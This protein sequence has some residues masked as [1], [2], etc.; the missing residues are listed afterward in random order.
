MRFEGP[1]PG[2]LAKKLKQTQLSGPT[3]S[4][5]NAKP[6]P[7]VLV[8]PGGGGDEPRLA[9]FR[10]ACEA[11]A[12]MAPIT[13][14]DWR[15]MAGS[16]F[17]FRALLNSILAQIETLAPEGPIHL[18][19]YCLGG[20]LAYAAAVTLSAKGR[21]IAFLGLLDADGNFEAASTRSLADRIR[22]FWVGLKR[23]Y[24]PDQLAYSLAKRLTR[25]LG[26][27]LLRQAARAPDVRMLDEFSLHLRIHV[28]SFLIFALR[29]EWCSSALLSAPPLQTP[30]FLFRATEQKFDNLPDLGW[31]KHIGTIES[32][33][34]GG[35]HLT[36]LECSN[37]P[38]LTEKFLDALSRC[39]GSN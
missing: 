29:R 34:V 24:K 13:Y 7:V 15:Q 6:L 21:R 19:G 16:S 28:R 27:T 14:P 39:T 17:D 31:H 35:D 25:G 8:L 2:A 10:I 23:I 3:S 4:S 26:L 36:M 38:L 18:T 32:I 20:F 37:L 5:T 9:Q 1:S 22:G 33:D 11:S 12:V 30:T